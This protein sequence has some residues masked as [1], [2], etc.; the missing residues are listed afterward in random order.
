M[1]PRPRGLAAVRKAGPAPAPV[2]VPAVE[3]TY[4]LDQDILTVSDLFELRMSAAELLAPDKPLTDG[5]DPQEDARGL[6][7]GILHGC[8]TLAG[9]LPSES[10]TTDAPD[11][12]ARL[13]ALG[14]LKP[15]AS[16]KLAFLQAYALHEMAAVLP[17]P[18]S[19]ASRSSAAGEG[20]SKRRKLDPAEPTRAVDWLDRCLASY[21][22]TLVDMPESPKWRALFNIEWARAL[23]DRAV[24]DLLLR[25]LEAGRPYLLQAQEHLVEALAALEAY[26]PTSIVDDEEDCDVSLALVRFLSAFVPA[27]DSFATVETLTASLES[28]S[29]ATAVLTTQC[30]QMDAEEDFW[31]TDGA[32]MTEMDVGMLRAEVQLAGLA[33][34]EMAVT[35]KY[36]NVDDE[37]EDDEET[38]LPESED[39]IASRVV[40]KAGMDSPL[41][42]GFS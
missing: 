25:A 14:L 33:I 7:R 8:S 13:T 32:P 28:L 21:A 35:E 15:L 5:E 26:E 31:D 37:P 27:V 34:R 22:V 10:T 1:P 23:V 17:A 6:L 11:V 2:P 9:F 36:R 41:L 20:S 39:V 18:T 16:H 4:P 29:V 12:T 42:Q 3:R 19:L 24:V 40:G 30:L 38:P